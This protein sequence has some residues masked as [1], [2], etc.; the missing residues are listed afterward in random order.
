VVARSVK[1]R[2]GDAPV[3]KQSRLVREIRETFRSL[4]WA[5]VL[6]LI[7]RSLAFQAFRIPSESMED[8]L[9]V[10]DFLFINKLT[11]GPRIP[12][13][14]TRLPGFRDPQPGDIIVFDFPRDPSQDYIKR[15]VAVEGQ[16]VE[17]REKVLYV[18]G[19]PQD[20]PFV[21]HS[22]PRLRRGLDEYGPIRVPEGKLFMMGD[23]RDNSQDSRTWGLLDMAHVH[24]K[25][26]II[27]FSWDSEGRPWYR[28]QPRLRRILSRIH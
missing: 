3:K 6:F 10:G 18:D 12:F 16:T 19:I 27:Y 28:G 9:L 13:T 26:E 8:T 21:K 24:G 4:I 14:H 20:E 11:Y 17:I 23:N 7:I 25:A 22:N 5:V 2:T 15:C 1:T